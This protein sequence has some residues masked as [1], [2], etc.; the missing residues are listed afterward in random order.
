MSGYEAQ[1]AG[2]FAFDGSAAVGTQT[3]NVENLNYTDANWSE[4][5]NNQMQ[6]QAG[7]SR[8]SR[9]VTQ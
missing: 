9:R 2:N 6:S 4:Y 1:L 7:A 3:L 5:A 8:Y